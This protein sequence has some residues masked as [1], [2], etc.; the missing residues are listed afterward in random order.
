MIF[1]SLYKDLRDKAMFDMLSRKLLAE[2]KSYP[3]DYRQ[4]VETGQRALKF[5]SQLRNEIKW[6]KP[7]LEVISEI[8]DLF[9]KNFSVRTKHESTLSV[10]CF[11]T[12]PPTILML[13]L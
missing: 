9:K 6:T 11:E 10:Q 7:V 2:W 1:L 3:S 12:C 8:F 5:H 4:A 13:F